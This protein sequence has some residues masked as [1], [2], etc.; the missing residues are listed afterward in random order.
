MKVRIFSEDHPKTWELDWDNIPREGDTVSF[1]YP[2][3]TTTQKVMS[4]RW[5]FDKTGTF[6]EVEIHLTY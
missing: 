5:V 6:E 1:N 3:G 4:V 2:G